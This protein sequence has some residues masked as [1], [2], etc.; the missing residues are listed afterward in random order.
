MLGLVPLIYSTEVADCHILSRY[1]I[2]D[3]I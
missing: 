3:G 2:P 1:P